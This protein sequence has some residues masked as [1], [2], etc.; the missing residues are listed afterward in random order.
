MQENDKSNV[1]IRR[2]TSSF[3]SHPGRVFVAFASVMLIL[4]AALAGI[5]NA[6]MGVDEVVVSTSGL[7]D[8][9]GLDTRTGDRDDNRLD[10]DDA[11]P[12]PAFVT[13][14]V[15]GA[16]LHPDVIQLPEGSRVQ[17]A[18]EACGGLAS[19][20]DVSGINRASILQDGQKVLVPRA[21]EAPQNSTAPKNDVATGGALVNINV[22]TL[23]ELEELP[24]IGEATARAIIDERES[25]G[26]YASVED[27]MRV[28]GIGEKKFE[29][30]RDLICV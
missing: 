28:S 23:E 9:A 15:D 6:K 20:A 30:L 17:D 11:P 24:G 27:L 3:R 29:K 2:L 10:S 21:G 7:G 19:D 25:S 22:A 8:S 4:G 13:V 16:V 18:I 26:P 1:M 14:D 5:A 12:G